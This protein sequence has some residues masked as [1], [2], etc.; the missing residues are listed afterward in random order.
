MSFLAFALAVFTVG[1][2]EDFYEK[3]QSKYFLKKLEISGR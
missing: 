3:G 2:I 1:C